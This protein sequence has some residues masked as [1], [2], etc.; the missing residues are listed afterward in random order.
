VLILHRNLHLNQAKL[1]T[2]RLAELPDFL[3]KVPLPP[4][5]QKGEFKESPLTNLF[6]TNF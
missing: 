1:A 2:A 5:A 4:H 3:A 6:Q